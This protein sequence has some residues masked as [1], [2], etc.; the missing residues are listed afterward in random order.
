M[1]DLAYIVS[2]S[3]SGST[4]LTFLL[5]THPQIG[6]IGE[7]KATSRGDVEQ[8]YCSCGKLLRQCTFWQQ[9][10]EEL[11]Q[12][13]VP[14]D[15]A[16]FGTHFHCVSSRFTD[17]LLRTAV[18]G[19]AFETIRTAGLSILPAAR[20]EFNSVLYKNR[21]LIDAILKLQNAR[22]FL[23]GSK[24]PIRLKYLL[25][26]GYWNV[27]VV[28][29]IRDGRGAANSYMNH[30][31]VDM[32]NAANEWKQCNE[33]AERVLRNLD[34]SQW[35]E[36][37]YEDLCKDTENTV[38]KLCDFLGVDSGKW[39][40]DFHSAENHVFGNNMRLNTTSEIRLDEKWKA[41]LTE[42]QLEVFDE[43][44]GPMN[45]KYGYE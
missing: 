19:R 42:E 32:K 28:F 15:I 44:A 7:L 30:H 13:G 39:S 21:V 25:D 10:G 11:D 16:D 36:A 38:G 6:T 29:L 3:Y 24:D 23:D 1:V 37:H 33:E 26:S 2:A 27:K 14:F 45:R 8:Y 34:K 35:I 43:V 9:V 12:D 40:Q 41:A 18:R 22:V 4:L 17:R 5:G 20:R 31:N